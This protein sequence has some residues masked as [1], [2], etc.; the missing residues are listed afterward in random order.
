ML[1][2]RVDLEAP[3][4]KDKPINLDRP[5]KNPE[6][7][8]AKLLLLRS[9][10][11]PKIRG[12]LGEVPIIRCLVLWGLYWVPLFRETVSFCTDPES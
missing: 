10:Q 5:W 6:N 2:K 7:P 8:N 11:F 4:A 3:A 12:T 9:W 1:H